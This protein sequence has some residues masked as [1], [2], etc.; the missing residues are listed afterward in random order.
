LG[1]G[2]QK[3]QFR[4]FPNPVLNGPLPGVV[5]EDLNRANNFPVFAGNR[6]YTNRHGNPVAIF[7]AK[8]Q[9]RAPRTTIRHGTAE[10]AVTG[11]EWPPGFVD[12]LQDIVGTAF[13]DNFFGS[14]SGKIFRCQVP[15][16]DPALTIREVDSVKEVVQHPFEETVHH[17]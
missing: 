16:D 3:C 10:R 8:I 7:V 2:I 6:A 12:V 1:Y 14:V 11:A 9:L 4:Q 5:I 17:I 13:P 15:V